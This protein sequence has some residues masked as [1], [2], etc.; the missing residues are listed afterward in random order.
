MVKKNLN[1]LPLP[2]TY[3]RR[4]SY[5]KGQRHARRR[6]TPRFKRPCRRVANRGADLALRPLAIALPSSSTTVEIIDA[7]INPSQRFVS[8]FGVRHRKICA[9]RSR[10]MEFRRVPSYARASPIVAC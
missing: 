8:R 1:S 5:H 4:R 7:A 2:A 3:S 9:P 10:R 6:M